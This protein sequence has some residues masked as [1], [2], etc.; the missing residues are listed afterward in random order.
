MKQTFWS[1][2]KGQ[3]ATLPPVAKA[4]L[5]SK[6]VIVLGANTGLGF[7]AVKHFARMNPGRVIMA[8][9]SERRGQAALERELVFSSNAI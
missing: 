3:F 9:R 2:L 1:I 7:E 6:T 8:C 5:A 4:D